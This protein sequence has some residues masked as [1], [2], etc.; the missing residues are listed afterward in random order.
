M[1]KTYQQDAKKNCPVMSQR[2]PQIWT[3]ALA[4]QRLK[5]ML[6]G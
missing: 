6:D 4:S 5:G 1:P 3:C 2:V